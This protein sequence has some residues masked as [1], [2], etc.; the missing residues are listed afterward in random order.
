MALTK[1][2]LQRLTDQIIRSLEGKVDV[3]HLGGVPA[4]GRAGGADRRH[5]ESGH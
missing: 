3:S 5:A 2:E 1:E 4:A